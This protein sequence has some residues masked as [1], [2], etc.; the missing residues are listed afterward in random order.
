[1]CRPRARRPPARLPRQHPG[2]PPVACA[3]GHQRQRPRD[4][5]P[6]G[7]GGHG[8]E[9]QQHADPLRSRLL[10][11]PHHLLAA[12]PPGRPLQVGRLLDAPACF[13]GR[14][15]CWG[16][17]RVVWFAWRC[18][19]RAAAGLGAPCAPTA[20]DA[21][22]HPPG[23]AAPQARQRAP[24]AAAAHSRGGRAADQA[25]A[26]HAGGQAATVGAAAL[27]GAAQL[28]LRLP[29][30]GCAGPAQRL[31]QSSS[32]AQSSCPAPRPG[33]RRCCRC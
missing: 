8:D 12:V 29:A 4:A 33:T 1:M 28:P 26:G 7:A 23:A 22:A 2:A 11:R 10:W 3:Q 5:R 9:P 18:A 24:P 6:P 25:A 30:A 27:Q 21:C 13:A 32:P 20:A 19:R 14:R 31:P 16:A 15:R 17:R